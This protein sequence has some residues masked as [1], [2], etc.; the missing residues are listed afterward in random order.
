MTYFRRDRPDYHRRWRVS[1]SCSRWEGVV[2]RRYGRQT[3]GWPGAGSGE[4]T[5]AA[6][7]YLEEV[8]VLLPGWS[9]GW[10]FGWGLHLTPRAAH[11]YRIKLHGQ[12]VRV[13]LTHYCA[14][15]PRLSTT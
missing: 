1:R 7:T 3:K 12:L 5:G 10:A 8:R 9:P 15:T 2:P 4:A 13:S 14:S 6:G 11:G